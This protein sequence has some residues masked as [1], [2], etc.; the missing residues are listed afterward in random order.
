MKTKVPEGRKG[1]TALPATAVATG[2]RPPAR[3][4]SLRSL[5]QKWSVVQFGDGR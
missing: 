5:W 3:E 2:T 1:F 4:Q